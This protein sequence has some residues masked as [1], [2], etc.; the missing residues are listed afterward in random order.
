MSETL[1]RAKDSYHH[2]TF[3]LVSMV[4]SLKA[5]IIVFLHFDFGSISP[6]IL[7]VLLFDRI[8][9]ILLTVDVKWIPVET[10]SS[11]V[12]NGISY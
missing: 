1:W 11:C 4:R 3:L 10:P 6:N 8:A 7:Y 2:V 5:M 12:C 9:Q